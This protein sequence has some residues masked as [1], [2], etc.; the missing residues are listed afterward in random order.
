VYSLQI[1]RKDPCI[2]HRGFAGNYYGQ[3]YGSCFCKEILSSSE[4]SSEC[5]VK[6]HIAMTYTAL[7]ILKTLGDDFSRI[8]K[9]S[10]IEGRSIYFEQFSFFLPL[11][12]TDLF[13]RIKFN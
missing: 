2:G 1:S 12:S 13:H 3:P 9:L 6:G 7:A 4:S 5:I 10:L 11:F 8:D